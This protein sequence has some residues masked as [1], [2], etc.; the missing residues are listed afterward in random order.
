MTPYLPLI[1]NVAGL[2]CGFCLGVLWQAR[3]P[4]RGSAAVSMVVAEP[5]MALARVATLRVT[6]EPEHGPPSIVLIDPPHPCWR[7]TVDAATV[8]LGVDADGTVRLDVRRLP[9]VRP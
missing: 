2:V 3:Q 5:Q 1:F 6:V 8:G 4:F 7:L 9:E